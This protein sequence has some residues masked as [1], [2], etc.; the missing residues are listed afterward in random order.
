MP[1]QRYGVKLCAFES[2]SWRYTG[3]STSTVKTE[4]A[5]RS[6]KYVI[7]DVDQTGVLTFDLELVSDRP[8]N[9]YEVNVLHSWLFGKSGYRKLNI[10]APDYSGFYF[11]CYMNSPE[12]YYI[13]DG[14]NGMK[15]NVVCDAPGAWEEPKIFS[16]KPADGSTII[17]NNTSASNDYVYPIVEFTLSSGTEFAITNMTDDENRPFSFSGLTSGEMCAVNGETGEITSSLGLN[18]V[19]CFNK[20]FLR[21]LPGRNELKCAG[22]VSS[23]KIMYAN[24]VRLGAG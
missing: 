8:L 18:R 6:L 9:S 1:S 20:K 17:I 22:S 12:D 14:F 23:L 15:F 3:G 10:Q 5:P 19:G 16:F 11:N 4:K 2:A 13:Q 21:L 7:Q 24:F